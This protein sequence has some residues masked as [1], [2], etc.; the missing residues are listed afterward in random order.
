AAVGLAALVGAV[1]FDRV[2]LAAAHASHPTHV[3]AVAAEPAHDAPRTARAE[4]EGAAVTTAIVGV[5]FD[6]GRGGLRVGRDDRPHVLEDRLAAREDAVGVGRELDALED[7]DDPGLP[8]QPHVSRATVGG[9]VAG[10]EG[11]LVVRVEHGVAVVVGVGAAVVVLKAVG[12]LGLVRA[13]VLRVGHAIAVVVEVGAAVGVFV[14]VRVLGV[15]RAVV[16]RVR[17]AVRVVVGVGATVVVL[18]AVLVF[19]L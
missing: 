15:V 16:V 13:T 4:L 18:E 19:R 8:I 12:V 5:A 1:L 6:S 14:A 2:Q 7:A 17:H 10:L 9:R 3:D 11:A